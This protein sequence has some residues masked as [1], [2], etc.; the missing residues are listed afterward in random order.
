MNVVIYN[1]FNDTHQTGKTL[2]AYPTGIHGVLKDLFEKAGHNVKVYTLKNINEITEDVLKQTDVMV[3]WG[4]T[5]HQDVSDA[6]ADKVA[7]SVLKGMGFIALHSAHLAKPF[8]RLMGTACNLKW[9]E[10]D[11]K[12]RV[13][14]V[15]PNHPI[16][17]GINEYFEIPHEEM[18]GEPFGIPTPDE[19]VFIGWFQGG[20]VFRS[21]CCYYRGNGKV[22]YFQPG[23]ETNPTFCIKE[24]QQVLLNA[25]N[26]AKPTNK[27]DDLSCP[28]VASLEEIKGE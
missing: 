20:N 9:R 28:M 27:I 18:Y 17:K 10:I 15:L 3:W 11:E 13:W 22:F 12:E 6:V 24:V 1:E 5:N 26:W 8:K 21:G 25:L 4:H 2:K 7:E 14:V 16:A 23:H 19:L